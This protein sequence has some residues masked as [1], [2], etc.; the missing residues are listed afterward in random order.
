MT[1]LWSSL[2]WNSPGPT[3]MMR[4]LV[5]GSNGFLAQ[6]FCE[7]LQKANL[8][9]VLLGLSKSENRNTF[10][11]THQFQQI[12]LIEFEKL[13]ALL[14]HFNPTHILHTA[15]A[16]SVEICEQQPAMAKQINVDL[17]ALLAEYCA[18]T[19]TH[20]TFLSTDF[21]FDGLNG[22][23]HEEDTTCPV[24]AYGENKIVAENY[25]LSS[26]ANAAIIRTILVYGAIPDQ[27]RSNLVLWAKK[28]LEDKK[29]IKVVNDQWRM[30][31]WV[32][33]LAKG[34]LLAM[35]QQA[36]GVF[37][38]SG[39]EMLSIEEAVRLVADYWKL[40]KS[41][42]V[43]ISATEI[44]QDKNRPKKTGFNIDKAKTLLGFEPTP[45][46]VSLQEIERQLKHYV[47]S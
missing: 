37:H 38:L 42:I 34:C 33:D 16:A 4:I 8:Q 46:I 21:V 41:L 17:T 31:T 11:Q 5:T 25:I 43:S 6:K 9:H 20:L 18:K 44:G 45:F 15:A 36:R 13:N 19:G 14:A 30:P 28:Q 35:Q 7:M 47:N 12:D 22:P 29:T 27:G 32:D 24:N 2:K 39:P 26:K 3:N 23:Y 40:D 1:T 10:L